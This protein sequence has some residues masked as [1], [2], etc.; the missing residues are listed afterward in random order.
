MKKTR[1]SPKKLKIFAQKL[2]QLE[3]RCL[4]Y[5][6]RGCPKKPPVLKA[7]LAK[8]KLTCKRKTTTVVPFCLEKIKQCKICFGINPR[9]N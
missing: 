8:G 3:A 2:S 6:P 9:E 4:P 1:F 5:P 7:K